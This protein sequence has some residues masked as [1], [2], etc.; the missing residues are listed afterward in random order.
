MAYSKA[1]LESSGDKACPC[2]RALCIGNMSDRYLPIWTL[3]LVS[4]RHILISRTSFLGIQ[5]SMRMFYTISLLSE[6]YTF[7]K[8]INS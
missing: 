4:F 6:T 7:L 1:K 8:S 3:V 5:D 2:F